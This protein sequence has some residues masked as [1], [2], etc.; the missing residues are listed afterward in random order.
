MGALLRAGAEVRVVSYPYLPPGFRSRQILSIFRFSA[1]MARS[2]PFLSVERLASSNANTA[3]SLSV[4]TRADES[5]NIRSKIASW[6]SGCSSSIRNAQRVWA[7]GMSAFTAAILTAGSVSWDM[8]PYNSRFGFSSP[9][10]S[11]RFR[12]CSI[13]A[14]FADR[15]RSSSAC[16]DA[17]RGFRSQPRIFIF[18]SRPWE[19]S[20]AFVA[21]D[22]CARLP[23]AGRATP[24]MPTFRCLARGWILA[25]SAASV[26]SAWPVREGVD[27]C[28]TGIGDQVGYARAAAQ[29]LFQ[30]LLEFIFFAF[31]PLRGNSPEGPVHDFFGEMHHLIQPRLE[32]VQRAHLLVDHFARIQ[33]L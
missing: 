26:Q 3:P 24:C 4:A 19:L 11:L 33:P 17:F 1:L 9:G 8:N 31:Q 23:P 22:G 16:P 25:R 15:A 21:C 30:Q 10:S 13:E 32:I 12:I 14:S 20:C 6:T 2:S 27:P 7:I 28:A 18:V 5:V 29:Q